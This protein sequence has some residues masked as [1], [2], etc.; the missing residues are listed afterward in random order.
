ML[1]GLIVAMLSLLMFL[2]GCILMAW[3]LGR[4]P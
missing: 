2:K 4:L 1:A 3:G